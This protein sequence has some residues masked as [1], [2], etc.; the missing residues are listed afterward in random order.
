M[1]KI[2]KI[3]D[4]PKWFNL[5][6]YKNYEDADAKEW[7]RAIELI[8]ILRDYLDWMGNDANKWRE[9]FPELVGK[10]YLIQDVMDLPFIL[11]LTPNDLLRETEMGV[12]EKRKNEE[13]KLRFPGIQSMHTT[14]RIMISKTVQWDPELA[15]SA[16]ESKCGDEVPSRP[17]MFMN[18]T[19][20]KSDVGE[21][22]P[23]KISG[24]VAVDLWLPD[25][26]LMKSFRAWIKRARSFT[27]QACPKG[28]FG[29]ERLKK[30]HREGYIP[31]W[32]LRTWAEFNDVSISQPVLFEA[33]F[34]GR[35]DGNVH[36]P[37]TLDH[38]RKVNIP[39]YEAWLSDK[40][41]E[42]LCAEVNMAESDTEE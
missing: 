38:L 11:F 42:A 29:I 23:M 35:K 7:A 34:P 39:N 2:K 21:D 22:P 30:W 3:S 25:A 27:G 14:H 1:K 9:K 16:A 15:K 37:V 5:D 31:Y 26:V 24:F 17:P 4:L 18:I 41:F 32:I 10:N 8:F 28:D 6:N 36:C 12:I 20:A 40:T 19:G 13:E 33:L